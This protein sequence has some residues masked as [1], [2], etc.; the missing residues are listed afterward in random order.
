MTRTKATVA[1]E[2][3]QSVADIVKEFRG[4]EKRK[5][6]ES[7]VR[8]EKFAKIKAD[9]AAGLEAEAKYL[10]EAL[11]EATV[12]TID[13]IPVV[14]HRWRSTVKVDKDLLK[15]RYLNVYNAVVGQV[16][17]RYLDRNPGSKIK[18]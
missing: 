15:S 9:G 11:G 5:V 12:G 1:P 2:V 14:T 7:L 6:R 16:K 13:G 10:R 4:H 17:S 3:E 8:A 18:G